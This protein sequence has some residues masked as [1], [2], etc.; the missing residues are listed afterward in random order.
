MSDRILII[1]DH[2]LVAETLGGFLKSINYQ[3]VFSTSIHNARSI[4]AKD[5]GFDI[6]LLDL[7]LPHLLSIQ[8]VESIVL[9]AK[10]AKTLLF[11][12]HADKQTIIRAIEVGA[13]GFVPKTFSLA[14][15]QSVLNLVAS[16]Q[17]FVPAELSENAL[18][19]YDTTLS[20]TELFVVREISSGLTNKQVAVDLNISEASV[21]MHMRM[22]CKKLGA[23]NRAHAVSIAQNDNLIPA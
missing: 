10:S 14:S 13:R 6:V 22:I 11:S 15:L 16:G 17:I 5:S 7:R 20:D 12:A 19:K 21:K 1:D 18:E 4:L 9:A 8:E 3:V 2:L 23:K